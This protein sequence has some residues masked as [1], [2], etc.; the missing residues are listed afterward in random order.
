MWFIPALLRLLLEVLRE[1]SS[2]ADKDLD[3]KDANLHA[4]QTI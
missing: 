1:L 2:L 4:G 3:E